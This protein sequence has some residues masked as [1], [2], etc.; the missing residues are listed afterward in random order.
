MWVTEYAHSQ[1][2]LHI[3]ETGDSLQCLAS[4]LG[5][6]IG[7]LLELNPG[8]GEDELLA[9]GQTII[10]PG[11]HCHR[12]LIVA[13]S[14]RGAEPGLIALDVS[15]GSV[16]AIENG[17]CVWSTVPRLSPC[18]DRIAFQGSDGRVRILSV[19][20]GSPTVIRDTP[21]GFVVPRWS[22]SGQMLAWDTDGVTTVVD[23]LGSEV[24]QL[25][26]NA[27]SWVGDGNSILLAC[28]GTAIRNDL[29]E[30]VSYVLEECPGQVIAL[31]SGAVGS[32]YAAVIRR[33]GRMLI[34]TADW[35][36]G[37][38]GEIAAPQDLWPWSLVWSPDCKMLAAEA[39]P[40]AGEADVVNIMLF[41]VVGED[42]AL[43]PSGLLKVVTDP[44]YAGLSW[45]NDSSAVAVSARMSGGG[46]F[47]I[48][49]GEPCGAL[50]RLTGLGDC[51]LPDWGSCV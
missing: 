38:V 42:V 6:P 9:Q 44:R 49:V 2:R 45:N 8:I 21:R 22:P 23:T 48:Y 3:A 46:A 28:D 29:L 17:G 43:Q 40:Q 7:A 32:R 19:F 12:G 51:V 24:M 20:G 15:S 36:T 34:A 27:P 39:G 14:N 30:G 16:R 25:K 35:F 47:A 37:E 31:H 26:G 50:H 5:V 10:A 4:T 18:G 13:V 1:E 41:S 11:T 33:D